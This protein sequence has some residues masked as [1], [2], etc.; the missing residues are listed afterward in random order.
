MRAEQLQQG[1]SLIEIIFAISIFVVGVVTIG[2]LTI[3]AFGSIQRVSDSTQARLLAT[4]GIEAVISIKD[5]N[6]SDI[7][8]GT[9]EL[10]ID[11][12]RWTLSSSADEK[13]KFT[14]AITIESIDSEV[15]EATSLVTWSVFGGRERSVTY[16]TFLSNWSQTN[17]EAGNLGVSTQNVALVSFDT[18]VIGLFLQNEGSSDITITD[19]SVSWDTAALLERITIEGIDVWSASTSN[20]VASETEID[21]TDYTIGESSGFHYINSLMF[22]DSMAGSNLV[23]IFTLSDGSTRSIYVSP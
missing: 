20:P 15:F 23:I 13:G 4:E 22:N 3:D 18:E 19:M 10:L 16:K 6:F 2:Y 12:G 17:G 7:T 1:Q 11:N 5:G 14:R 8:A 21:I 9:Y